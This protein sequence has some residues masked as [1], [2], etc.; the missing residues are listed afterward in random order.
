MGQDDSVSRVAFDLLVRSGVSSTPEVQELSR[1]LRRLSGI[2]GRSDDYT[3]LADLRNVRAR[4]FGY[5]RV[6]HPLI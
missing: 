5:G 4:L 1:H 6:E 2:T 3:P